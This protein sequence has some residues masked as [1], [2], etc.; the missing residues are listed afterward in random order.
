M[1]STL[2]IVITIIVE[3]WND[4]A[5]SVIKQMSRRQIEPADLLVIRAAY[6]RFDESMREQNALGDLAIAEEWSKFGALVRASAPILVKT[7]LSWTD[8][9]QTVIRKQR[10]YGK[11]NIRRFGQH[12]LFVRVHDKLARLEHL[13][14][15]GATPENE[16]LADTVLDLVGYSVLGV[17]L[18][19]GWFD[20]PLV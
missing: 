14:A 19:C 13:I 15:S 11:E 9:G 12:G 5:M 8:I 2:L 10:D 17:M 7:N 1:R 3:S 20:L 18:A 4:A 6:D 16:S